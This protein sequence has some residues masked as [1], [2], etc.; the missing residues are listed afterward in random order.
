MET[1]PQEV[2]RIA[3]AA[4]ANLQQA[5]NDVLAGD[6]SHG[7]TLSQALQQFTTKTQPI[8]KIDLSVEIQELYQFLTQNFQV[9]GKYLKPETAKLYLQ[10]TYFL[11][12]W[13]EQEF[14]IPSP[15]INVS[16]IIAD[17]PNIN[18]PDNFPDWLQKFW[19]FISDKEDS[20]SLI[21]YRQG[22][23]LTVILA[24]ARLQAQKSNNQTATLE[25]LSSRIK[26]IGNEY[27][28]Y[29]PINSQEKNGLLA[30]NC[31]V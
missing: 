22:V 23:I 2:F 24:V 5:H 30:I 14:N 26:A 19:H 16:L 11:L 15:E 9:K 10:I 4:L 18:T 25:L 12:A 17:F 27:K 20:Y 29:P 28:Q 21:L 13:L 6:R 8:N 31:R 1:H 7:G 3:E